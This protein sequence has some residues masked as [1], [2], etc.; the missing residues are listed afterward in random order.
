MYPTG[1]TTLGVQTI[2]PRTF[3]LASKYNYASLHIFILANLF[4]A[5]NFQ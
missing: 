5:D 2:R 3:H 4:F 1:F